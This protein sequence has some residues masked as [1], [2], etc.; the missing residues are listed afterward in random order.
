MLLQFFPSLKSTN[1]YPL[2]LFSM[3]HIFLW[4]VLPLPLP[5]LSWPPSP[6]RGHPDG[7][8]TEH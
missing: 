6:D 5:R 4:I 3:Y 8:L 1:T 2:E 7:A